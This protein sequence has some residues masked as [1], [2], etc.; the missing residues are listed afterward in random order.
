MDRIRSQSALEYMITYGW[1]ILLVGV[2]LGLVFYLVILSGNSTPTLCTAKSPYSCTAPTFSSSSNTLSLSM[3]QNSGQPYFDVKLACATTTNPNAQ[4]PSNLQFSDITLYGA[5]SNSINSGPAVSLSG[6]PCY[7]PSGVYTA[8]IG[9]SFSVVVWL[10]YDFNTYSPSIQYS[11][12]TSV[13]TFTSQ[14]ATINL[15]VS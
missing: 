4:K 6:I 12:A 2:A 13:Q 5:A 11:Y 14:L 9:T 3:V 1:A 15:H 8:P 10:T 7:G